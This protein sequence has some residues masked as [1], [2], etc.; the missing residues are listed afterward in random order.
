MKDPSV[1]WNLVFV[2]VSTGPLSE[3]LEPDLFELIFW[4]S[5]QLHGMITGI[6]ESA[7]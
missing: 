5:E 6:W 2:K 1:F 4:I 7:L 3:T